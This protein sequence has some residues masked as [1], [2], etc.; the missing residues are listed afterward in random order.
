MIIV[1]RV[2]KILNIF[3]QYSKVA[4]TFIPNN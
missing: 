4:A 1:P 2:Y 3:V